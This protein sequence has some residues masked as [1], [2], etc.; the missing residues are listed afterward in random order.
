MSKITAWLYDLEMRM[1][2]GKLDPRRQS[3]LSDVEGRTLEVGVG[4]GQNLR[5]YQPDSWVVG[6]D[7][8]PDMLGRAQTRVVEAAAPVHLMAAAGES[9]PF[10][11]GAFDAVVVTLALCS[12]RS[13][14]QVLREIHRVLKSGGKLHFME[15][16]RSPGP[17]WAR[18]QDV[19]TPAWKKVASG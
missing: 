10:A 4:T 18:F 1:A 6:I 16:V 7:P 2:A 19:V 9:L 15:H 11:A 5:F 13:Q 14:D 12:V 8:D 3:L 17:G